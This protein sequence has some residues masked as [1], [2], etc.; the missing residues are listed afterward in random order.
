MFQSDSRLAAQALS[1]GYSAE[2][3]LKNLQLDIQAGSITAIIGANG[4]GK[5]T[6][7]KTLA[8]KLTPSSGAVMLDGK[9]ISTISRRQVSDEIAFLSQHPAANPFFGG[10]DAGWKVNLHH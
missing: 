9:S 3:V 10:C 7:L 2:T 8:R 6:L 5:S 4:S 1:A